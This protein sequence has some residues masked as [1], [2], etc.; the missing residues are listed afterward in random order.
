MSATLESLPAETPSDTP[1]VETAPTSYWSEAARPLASLWFTLP[2]LAAYEIG[3]LSMGAEALRNGADVWLR[4]AL[5]EVGFGAWCLLPVLAVGILL[6]WHHVTGQRWRVGVTV[7]P[8]MVIESFG[9]AILLT[10][11]ASLM[12]WGFQ[13]CEPTASLN[14]AS[15][16]IVAFLGA[17]VYEELLFRMMLLPAI[18]AAFL[19]V[20]ATRTQSAVVAVVISSLIFSAAHYDFVNA[21]GDTFEWFTFT[22]RFVA[23]VFFSCLFLKRGFGVAVGAHAI[24][25][26]LVGVW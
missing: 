15:S 20:G 7:V 19:A 23:G 18:I 22:F 25:D 2:I 4:Q 21:Y 10:F 26:I 11:I 12:C 3:V 6:A 13:F 9:W 5:L 17:G 24:Y 8:A 1:V 16:R 14:T